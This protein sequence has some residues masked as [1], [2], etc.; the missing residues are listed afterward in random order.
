MHTHIPFSVTTYLK[1]GIDLGTDSATTNCD[2]SR[3]ILSQDLK[4]HCESNQLN[5]PFS[6]CLKCGMHAI[7]FAEQIDQFFLYAMPASSS[8]TVVWN[9]K[10]FIASSTREHSGGGRQNLGRMMRCFTAPINK[11][12]GR[13]TPV[14]FALWPVNSVPMCNHSVFRG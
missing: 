14:Q 10:G 13:L 7:S 4:R 12:G 8:N 6:Y 2:D 11:A 3:M 5:L 1:F 9:A